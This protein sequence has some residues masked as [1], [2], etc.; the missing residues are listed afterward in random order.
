VIYAKQ[1]QMG[2][3]PVGESKWQGTYSRQPEHILFAGALGLGESDREQIEHRRLA[4]GS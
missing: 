2:L 1:Q 3:P 4:L